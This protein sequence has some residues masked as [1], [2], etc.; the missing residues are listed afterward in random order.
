MKINID[1]PLFHF[2]GTLFDFV[3]LNFIF[4]LSC[5][6]IIT[7]G[8]ALSALY[9]VVLKEVRG[10]HGYVVSSYFR[11][12]KENLL[13]STLTFVIYAI[14]L[15][16][17]V[18]NLAF[19]FQISTILGN[20]IFCILIIL[21]IIYILSFIYVFALNARFEASIKN[22]IKNSI[23]IALSNPTQSL[24]LLAIFAVSIA[25]TYILPE[26]RIFLLLFGFSFI[27]YCAAFSINRVFA[28]YENQNSDACSED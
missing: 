26:F 7:I 25:L 1:T 19:W 20:I 23:L 24:I 12:F 4:L 13:N 22:T 6:P 5:I 15:L 16:V 27:T 10:E 3:V 11:A 18:F 9:Y 21:T 28:L 8:P 14:M 17:L 2:L